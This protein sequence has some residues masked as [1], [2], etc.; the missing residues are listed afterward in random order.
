[1]IRDVTL[2]PVTRALLHVDFVR[3]LLDRKLRV[4]VPVE[5]VGTA[6]GVKNE[7]GLLNVVTHE[8]EIECLP[9]D[10][11][12]TIKVDVTELRRPRRRSASR[13]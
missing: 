1:M 10:I 5:I 2:D 8:L 13:T 12:P 11:P 9:A 6:H 4:K 7:G 3:I